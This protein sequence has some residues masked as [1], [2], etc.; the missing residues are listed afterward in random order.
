MLLFVSL[1]HPDTA[2]VVQVLDKHRA[3]GW[4]LSQGIYEIKVYNVLQVGSLLILPAP[5]PCGR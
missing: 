4:S 5:V 1:L 2:P 3:A